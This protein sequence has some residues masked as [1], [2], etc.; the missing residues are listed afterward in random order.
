MPP[1]VENLGEKRSE[2]GG[3]GANQPTNSASRDFF[4]RLTRGGG[5]GAGHGGHGVAMVAMVAMWWPCGGHVVATGQKSTLGAV[6]RHPG[7]GVGYLCRLVGS[8]MT[9]GRRPRRLATTA[10]AEPTALPAPPATSTTLA[11]PA[12]PTVPFAA[13]SLVLAAAAASHRP[14]RR[15]RP[16]STAAALALATTT[17]CR[18]ITLTRARS[19]CVRA[20]RARPAADASSPHCVARGEST[21]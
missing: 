21:G 20:A 2:R 4:W 16:L 15:P 11:E 14:R 6:A 1:L 5:H 10:L 18:P 9:G 3:G 7:A 19:A 8:S 17:V 12:A 13:A